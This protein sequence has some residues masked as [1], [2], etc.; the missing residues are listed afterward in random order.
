MDGLTMNEL[1]REWRDAAERAKLFL[2]RSLTSVTPVSQQYNMELH[3]SHA[4][5]AAKLMA[6]MIRRQGI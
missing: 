2:T 5:K 1:V 4:A 3:N 6:E